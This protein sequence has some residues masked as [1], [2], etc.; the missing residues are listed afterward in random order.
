M[1]DLGILSLA[2]QF[3]GY[4]VISFSFY[5]RTFKKKLSLLQFAVVCLLMFTPILKDKLNFSISTHT[6]T[7][8]RARTHTHTE[9]N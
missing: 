4:V 3:W 7:R 9:G 2:L 6:R 8:A 5:W 1:K